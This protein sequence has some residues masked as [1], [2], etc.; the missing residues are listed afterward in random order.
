MNPARSELIEE[1]NAV[2]ASMAHDSTRHQAQFVSQVERL[3]GVTV[4]HVYYPFLEWLRVRSMRVKELVPL[5]GTTAATV[6]RHVQYLENLGLVERWLDEDDRRSSILGLTTKGL[7]VWDCVQRVRTSFV[8][9]CLREWP[10]EEIHQLL[11]LFSKLT[12]SLSEGRELT[13][14][15]DDGVPRPGLT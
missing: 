1:L 6:T 9:Q 12:R 10:T 11:P 3:S 14:V 2:L 5:V 15:D 13:E 4:S 7:D 8:E